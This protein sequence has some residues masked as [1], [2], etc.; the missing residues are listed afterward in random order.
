MNKKWKYEINEVGAL[1]T[2]FLQLK[3]AQQAKQW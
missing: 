3:F 2:T 1:Y